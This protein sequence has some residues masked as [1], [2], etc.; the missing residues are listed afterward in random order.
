MPAVGIAEVCDCKPGECDLGEGPEKKLEPTEVL[1]ILRRNLKH[2]G[3]EE[4][5]DIEE[6]IADVERVFRIAEGVAKE[7]LEDEAREGR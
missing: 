7:F 3:I 2:V 4:R 6:L 1:S 5:E